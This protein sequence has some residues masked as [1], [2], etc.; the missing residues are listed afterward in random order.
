MTDNAEA[1]LA[2]GEAL[3]ALFVAATASGHPLEG[4][5]IG[6]NITQS[7][8]YPVVVIGEMYP[9]DYSDK[10]NSGMEIILQIHLWDQSGASPSS[11]GSKRIKQGQSAIYG[12]LHNVPLNLAAS[13]P[14]QHNY[15]LRFQSAVGLQVE[16]DGIT[17]HAVVKYRVLT[18]AAN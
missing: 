3:Y 4:W 8:A 18:R 17:R 7:T 9:T 16:D 15:L 12:L 11:R 13:S 1:Q 10:S 14:K 2:V 5:T 6:D